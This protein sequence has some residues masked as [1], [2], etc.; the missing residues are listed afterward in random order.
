MDTIISIILIPF[1]WIAVSWGPRKVTV[2]RYSTYIHHKD[3]LSH[4]VSSWNWETAF[5]R[6]SQNCD[7]YLRNSALEEKEVSCVPFLIPS[8]GRRESQ[9]RW[10]F[11]ATAVTHSLSLASKPPGNDFPIEVHDNPLIVPIDNHVNP[12]I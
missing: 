3:A 9:D 7:L 2:S 5:Y 1:L 4:W 6:G 8:P 10:L 12:V 11:V